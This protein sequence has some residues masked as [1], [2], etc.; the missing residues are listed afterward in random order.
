IILFCP[1]G[2]TQAGPGTTIF[3]QDDTKS[4]SGVNY[5]WDE[6][7][8]AFPNDFVKDLT[9]QAVVNVQNYVS[10]VDVQHGDGV[11][12]S[13]TTMKGGVI[14]SR[15]WVEFVFGQ[16][17]KFATNSGACANVVVQLG[18]KHTAGNGLNGGLHGGV[19]LIRGRTPIKGS[20]IKLYGPFIRHT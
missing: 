7:F 3:Y 4:K 20:S 8:F 6:I 15:S 17:W 16:P 1:D 13:A 11:G 10:K 5:T 18:G 19:I 9:P 12:T 2:V 14:G